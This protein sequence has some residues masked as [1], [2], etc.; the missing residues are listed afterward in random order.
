M[1]L[2]D[3]DAVEAQLVGIGQ[4]VDVFAVEIVPLDRIVQT[5]G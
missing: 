3:A 5:V 2:V 1:M 4:R